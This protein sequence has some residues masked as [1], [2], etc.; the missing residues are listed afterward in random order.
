M[1]FQTDQAMM[2]SQNKLHAKS[3]S[4][5]A[6]LL[7]V[8]VLALVSLLLLA[9]SVVCSFSGFCLAIRTQTGHLDAEKIS[10]IT[11]SS[12]LGP[13]RQYDGMNLQSVAWRVKIGFPVA[14]CEYTVG[15]AGR[16]GG[17]L[18]I[19]DRPL[20]RY[21]AIRICGV[22]IVLA[23][24]A[25]IVLFG[26]MTNWALWFAICA[27]AAM[28]VKKCIKWNRR[29]NNTCPQCSYPLGQSSFCTECGS[30]LK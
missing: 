7:N 5:S 19:A 15:A 20:E 1:S 25:R 3:T 12:T 22:D 13:L 23:W 14:C 26:M 8:P 2:L 29:R 16:I 28:V 30:L 27:I 21:S 11:W 6:P 4:P 17:Q 24:P 10:D 9:T 18:V